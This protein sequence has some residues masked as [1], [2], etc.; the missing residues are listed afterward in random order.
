MSSDAKTRGGGF[1]EPMVKWTS[2]PHQSPDDIPMPLLDPIDTTLIGAPIFVVFYTR[3]RVNEIF[4]TAGVETDQISNGLASLR[5]GR[6]DEW[7]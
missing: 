6:V 2:P 5:C 3:T 7:R 4:N 1:S